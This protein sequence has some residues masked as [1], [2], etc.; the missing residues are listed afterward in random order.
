VV[1]HSR[2]GNASC[3]YIAELSLQ[4]YAFVGYRPSLVAAAAV[5]LAIQ[6]EDDHVR[7]ANLFWRCCEYSVSERVL[8]IPFQCLLVHPESQWQSKVSGISYRSVDGKRSG[9]EFELRC[10]SAN[11]R[12]LVLEQVK[13]TCVNAPRVPK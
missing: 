1:S 10:C 7:P 8:L 4:D 12:R 11:L 6:I 13:L 3:Q 2:D 9:Q 5:Y